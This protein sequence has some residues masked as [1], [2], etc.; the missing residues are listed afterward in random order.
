MKSTLVHHLALAIQRFFSF[1]KRNGIEM[2]NRKENKQRWWRW[3]L[4]NHNKWM[5]RWRFSEWTRKLCANFYIFSVLCA[6]HV[7]I[8]SWFHFIQVRV[9]V[10]WI[11]E[12][13]KRNFLLFCTKFVVW[14][15][16]LIAH[17]GGIL[18][19]SFVV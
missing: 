8:K 1:F 16:S 19:S 15:H 6:L 12:R 14:W 18:L 5:K 2:A 7:Q 4:S 17:F 13:L 10:P 11:K 9:Y 3:L